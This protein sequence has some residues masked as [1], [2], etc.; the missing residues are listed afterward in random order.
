MCPSTRVL[1]PDQTVRELLRNPPEKC[2]PSL[3]AFQG[4]GVNAQKTS[5]NIVFMVC[6]AGGLPVVIRD[7]AP[8]MIS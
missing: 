7:T 3:P 1:L 6:H 8:S 5:T 4:H 2:D